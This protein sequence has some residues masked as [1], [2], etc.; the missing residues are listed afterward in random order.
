MFS[1]LGITGFSQSNNYISS[2]FLNSK[3]FRINLIFADTVPQKI[4]M[5]TIRADKMKINPDQFLF[6]FRRNG[7]DYYKSKTDGLVLIVPIQDSLAT[8]NAMPNAL[9]NAILLK[10]RIKE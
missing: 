10:S 8:R 2:S 3:A 6:L 5:D 7:R 9:S 1:L 4:Y